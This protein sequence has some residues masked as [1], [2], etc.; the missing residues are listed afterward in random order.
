MPPMNSI[1]TARE[2]HPGTGSPKK[3]ART[4]TNTI[5]RTAH[6]QATIPA[7]EAKCKG[8]AENPTIPSME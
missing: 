2:G 1:N 4:S 7:M 8:A 3:A 5:P 6:A